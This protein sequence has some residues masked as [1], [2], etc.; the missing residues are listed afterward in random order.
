M[1]TVFTKPIM[2]IS[3]FD[4]ANVVTTSGYQG[5]SVGDG[6]AIDRSKYATSN[7][8]YDYASNVLSFQ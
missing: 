4:S 3:V 2:N 1:K 5:T 7:A 6:S 8:S